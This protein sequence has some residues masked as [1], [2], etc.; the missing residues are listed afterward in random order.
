MTSE[1]KFKELITKRSSIKGRVTKFKIYLESLVALESIS[2]VEVNKLAMKLSRM[3]ALFIEFDGLQSQ[4]EVHSEAN[5]SAELSTRDFIEQEFDNCIAIAQ[6]LIQSNS[7]APKQ[8]E[9][10]RSIAWFSYHLTK[11]MMLESYTRAFKGREDVGATSAP[12]NA[13]QPQ[14]SRYWLPAVNAIGT[15]RGM[16]R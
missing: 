8:V 2:A 3:E 13:T 7:S 10:E 9:G 12:R 11:A 4:I 15:T 1:L 6:D 16:T 14:P 5:Q